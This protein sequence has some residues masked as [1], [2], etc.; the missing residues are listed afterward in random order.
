MSRSPSLTAL[1]ELQGLGSPGARLLWGDSP[2]GLVWV[3]GARGDDGDVVLVANLDGVRRELTIELGERSL[4][5]QLEPLS[6]RR[7]V[8]AH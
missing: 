3:V 8:L 5:V 6:F 4:P 7:V 2:D 1:E